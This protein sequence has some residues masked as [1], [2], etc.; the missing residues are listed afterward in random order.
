MN[1]VMAR[2]NKVIE[3]TKT[4]RVKGDSAKGVPAANSRPFKDKQTLG[5][6]ITALKQRSPLLENLHLEQIWFDFGRMRG[7]SKS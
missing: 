7:V 6:I 1:E 4:F 5:S 3:S 2:L